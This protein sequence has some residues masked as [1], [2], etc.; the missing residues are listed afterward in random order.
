MK[1]KQSIFNK[2]QLL[3]VFIIVTILTSF[4]STMFLVIELEL[5]V[6]IVWL[7]SPAV[8]LFYTIVVIF[9]RKKVFL[10]LE[11]NNTHVALLYRKEVIHSI[12]NSDIKSIEIKTGKK[13]NK[14]IVIFYG[15]TPDEHEKRIFVTNKDILLLLNK[16]LKTYI[17]NMKDQLPLEIKY[18]KSY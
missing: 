14:G 11:I 2:L 18:S 12:N 9:R 1:D 6:Q 4:F 13:D 10:K 3:F 5:D 8:F 17:E 16:N 15:N 7:V